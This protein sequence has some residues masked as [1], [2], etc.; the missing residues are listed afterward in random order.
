MVANRVGCSDDNCC[1]PISKN[2]CLREA[3][4]QS[5]GNVI[6]FHHVCGPLHN[7]RKKWQP[8]RPQK[9]WEDDKMF[10]LTVAVDR[11]GDAVQAGGVAY[12]LLATVVVAAQGLF[13]GA[14]DAEAHRAFVLRWLGR[15]WRHDVS[16]RGS[17]NR[18][19]RSGRG[20]RRDHLRERA[21]E[22]SWDRGCRCCTHRTR[23]RS[24][25]G[26]S[27]EIPSREIARVV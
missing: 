3:V 23:D 19:R 13:L 11:I 5:G 24:D 6:S 21:S 10:V 9:L 17:W 1:V 22:S 26:R 20:S 25:Q 14:S 27:L 4:R 2:K 18:N 7:M 16:R 15:R 8:D 12:D